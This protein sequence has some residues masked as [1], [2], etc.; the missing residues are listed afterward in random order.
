MSLVLKMSCTH[1]T[2]RLLNNIFE[3]LKKYIIIFQAAKGLIIK[4]IEIKNME[5]VGENYLKNSIQLFRYYRSVGEK[6]I[7]QVSDQSIHWQYN[8]DS[9]SISIIVKHITG[10]SLS[11]WT[12]F[13][14]TDGQKEWRKRDYEFEKTD[15]TRSEMMDLWNQG[16]DCL[17]NAIEPLTEA[18]LS[19]TVYIRGEAHTVTEAINRQLAHL[20]YHI[21][22]IVFI[23]KMLAGQDW[24]S[25]TIPKGQSQAYEKMPFLGNFNR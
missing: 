24:K 1:T 11:R 12:D 10:N 15:F 25:L 9:N 21:G 22:Q 2:H 3:G 7:D 6:S 4:A 19:K 16:W 17:F 8:D 23:A 20:P 18:D 5:S 14:T 13:L